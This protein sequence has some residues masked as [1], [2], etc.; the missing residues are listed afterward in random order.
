M[1]ENGIVKIECISCKYFH[2]YPNGENYCFMKHNIY[3]I[4]NKNVYPKQCED[5]EKGG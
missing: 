4:N 1:T 2:K 5:Y 3:L